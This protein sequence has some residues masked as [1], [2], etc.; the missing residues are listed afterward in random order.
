MK[1]KVCLV[2]AGPGDYKLLTLKGLECIRKADVIVYDR[3]ANINYLKEAKKGCEFINV[4]KASSHHLLPQDQ[5][6][7]LIADKALERKTGARGLRA[8]ME[9]VMLDLM[10]RVPSDDSISKCVVDK[11]MVEN[12]LAL[13]GEEI[14]GIEQ[15]PK[16]EVKEELAS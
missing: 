6:N 4:G 2:G 10:Y 12:N 15:D 1:G 5:I 13:D 14:L 9:A 3:L 8:I 7:R 11:K 16:K